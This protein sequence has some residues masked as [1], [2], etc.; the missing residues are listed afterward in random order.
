M[1]GR[2]HR[3]I[4]DLLAFLLRQTSAGVGRSEFARSRVLVIATELAIEVAAA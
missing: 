2:I 4:L 1:P 3:A